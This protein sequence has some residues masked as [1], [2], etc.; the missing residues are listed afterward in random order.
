MEHQRDWVA[1]TGKGPFDRFDYEVT[2]G[3]K[4]RRR[5][6]GIPRLDA[7]GWR[8]DRATIIEVKT[9]VSASSAMQGVGQLLYY[10][11]AAKSIMGWDIEE[12]ILFTPSWPLFLIDTVRNEG[13][14]V[15]LVMAT[16]EE[17]YCSRYEGKQ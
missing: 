9:H 7:V 11:Q 8:G 2:I 3:E 15:T 5:V 16:P 4:M 10:K 1:V 13:L 12:L 14:P 6:A 17:F